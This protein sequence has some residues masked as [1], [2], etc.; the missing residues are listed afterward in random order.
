V[1]SLST[2]LHS[3]TLSNDEAELR[4]RIQGFDF[5]R[6]INAAFPFAARLARENGWT[7]E[8]AERAI[9]EYRRFVLLAIIAGHPVSPSEAVDQVWHLHL[10][11][12]RSYWTA[13][14][15]EVLRTPLHHDPSQGGAAER[16]KLAA[17]YE[18]TLTS[19]R[20]VF[21]HAPPRALWPAPQDRWGRASRRRWLVP[22]PQ[23]RDLS[24]LWLMA[25]GLLLVAGCVAGSSGGVG[26]PFD[27]AGP[28]FLIFYACVV[29]VA[30]TAATLLRR[31]ALAPDSTV[32]DLSAIDLMQIAYLNGGPGLAADAAIA[33]LVTSGHLGLDPVRRTLRPAP[34]SVRGYLE[35]R[36]SAPDMPASGHKGGDPTDGLHPLERAA[37]DRVCSLAPS[38]AAIDDVRMSIAGPARR[39]GERL[40]RAGLI[41]GD[42]AMI[43]LP[44]LV[45]LVAPMIG[46]VKIVIGVQRDRPIG[47]LLAATVASLLAAYL[48]FTRRP[49]RTRRGDLVLGAL[50]AAHRGIKTGGRAPS[51]APSGRDSIAGL[52]LHGHGFLAGGPLAALAC[53]PASSGG[54]DAGGDRGGGDGGGGDGGGGWWWLWRRRRL[55]RL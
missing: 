37:H 44:T 46:V 17:W 40:I 30:F 9:E 10:M 4:A 51:N 23:L 25:P 45:A 32:E 11:Y 28:D 13:F 7:A 42:D 15:G 24:A 16:A 20:R 2:E 50:R 1:N 36:E 55:W 33:S 3:R 54:G 26:S 14:C 27:L 41:V 43:I 18:A 34:G 8:Q 21:G 12:T 35:Y 52:A 53:P 38:A 19:Y 31:I 39:V 22:K 47:L 5:D 6:G 49:H 29:V 48:I